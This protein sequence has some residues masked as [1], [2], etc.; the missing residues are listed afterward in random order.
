MPKKK[1]SNGKLILVLITDYLEK[2]YILLHFE[3]IL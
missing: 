2:N 3:K 1:V